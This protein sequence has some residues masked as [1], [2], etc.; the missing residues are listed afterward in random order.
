MSFQARTSGFSALLNIRI[1]MHQKNYKKLF[2]DNAV[3]QRT[4]TTP[5]T[6]TPR[7]FLGKEDGQLHNF[8]WFG[9]WR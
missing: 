1:F 2:L 7:A 8:T 4:Q 6:R 9:Q 5:K 3:S